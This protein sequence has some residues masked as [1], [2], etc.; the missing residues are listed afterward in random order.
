MHI[1]QQKFLWIT[2]FMLA[3]GTQAQ[4]QFGIR[5]ETYGSLTNQIEYRATL[6]M[7]ANVF[8][9]PYSSPVG[10]HLLTRI[11]Y[12]GVS[13]DAETGV[14]LA[15]SSSL[16]FELGL[17]AIDGG[18]ARSLVSLFAGFEPI[19]RFGKEQY[20]DLYLDIIFGINATFAGESGLYPFWGIGGGFRVDVAPFLTDL[21]LVFR[22]APGFTFT[23]EF[24]VSYSVLPWLRIGF[25]L[26]VYGRIVLGSGG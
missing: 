22:S 23:G 21:K 8:S 20:A 9:G 6:N 4:A 25:G 15:F 2:L 12:T 3:F 10:A 26:W 1:F 13:S 24:N 14:R 7:L 5:F 16:R 17:G 18:Y 19:I 11:G